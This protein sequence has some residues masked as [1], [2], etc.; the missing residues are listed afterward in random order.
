LPVLPDKLSFSPIESDTGRI[1]ITVDVGRKMSKETDDARNA[2]IQAVIDDF[3]LS[4]AEKEYIAR[5]GHSLRAEKFANFLI[6][7]APDGI[8]LLIFEEESPWPMWKYTKMMG[9]IAFE[10]KPV[11]LYRS[12]DELM[13]TL[14]QHTLTF[15]TVPFE[16]ENKA[17][18]TNKRA[19]V[20]YV[21]GT[22]VRP[23]TA[24]ELD[25]LA[26]TFDGIDLTLYEGE[27]WEYDAYG[28]YTKLEI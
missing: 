21:H 12:I 7:N 18:S 13:E 27:A 16:G 20:Y 19:T 26:A 17:N 15:M 10:E 9:M 8:G 6:T 2:R 23:F 24:E 11:E 22:H 14:Q 28:E 4:L 3:M 25:E 5:N 1:W